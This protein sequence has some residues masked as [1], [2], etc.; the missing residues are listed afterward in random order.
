MC[1]RDL[2]VIWEKDSIRLWIL[3]LG[4]CKFWRSLAVVVCIVSLII[5]KIIMGG[6]IVHPSWDRSGWIMVY[7]SSFQLV[8]SAKP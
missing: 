3:E 7:L 5:A 4:I 8:A 1:V 6:S 2:I